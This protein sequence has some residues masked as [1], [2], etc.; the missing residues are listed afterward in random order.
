MKQSLTYLL[1]FFIALFTCQVGAAQV[2]DKKITLPETALTGLTLVKAIKNRQVYA[3]TMEKWSMQS[4]AGGVEIRTDSAKQLLDEYYDYEADPVSGV[5]HP[6][7]FM[8]APTYKLR[9]M[10]YQRKL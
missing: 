10:F 7:E 3:S 4:I 8:E 5:Y 6:Q 1:F 2:P 9:C